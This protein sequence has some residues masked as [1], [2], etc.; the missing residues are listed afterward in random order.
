MQ[1]SAR[2]LLARSLSLLL[3]AA[4]AGPL[5]AAVPG[6]W[7]SLGPD[8]GQI[9]HLAYATGRPQTMYAATGASGFRSLDGGASWAYA[10]K[11]L[12]TGAASLAIDPSDPATVYAARE[13]VSRSR[14]GG[15]TWTRLS[16][17][18]P[19]VFQLAA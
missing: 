6:S 13:G 14:D 5:S 7:R 3:L 9:Y 19:G 15:A 11:G 10:G 17:V 12:T 8:G 18:D 2:R 16:R 4:L 1:V